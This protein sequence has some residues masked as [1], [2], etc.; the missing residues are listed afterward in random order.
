MVIVFSH[1]ANESPQVRREVE[2]AVAKGL[3][4]IPIRIEDVLP[5]KALEYFIS[6]AHW[7][8]AFPPPL[9]VHL[10]KLADTILGFLGREREPSPAVA[11]PV[12]P[13]SQWQSSTRTRYALIGAA[14]TLAILVIGGLYWLSNQGKVGPPA[15]VPPTTGPKPV[16]ASLGSDAAATTLDSKQA[17]KERPF[18]N[19]LGMEFV[20]MPGT[21]VLFCRWETRVKDWAAFARV[22]KLDGGWATQQK[23]SVHVKREPDHPICDVNWEDANAFCRWLTEKESAEGTLPKGMRYRLPTD[24]E[25]SRAVGLGKEEGA[26]PA[27]KSGKN[28]VDFPWGISWPP[29]G[30]AGN[31]ADEAYHAEFPVENWIKDYSDGFATTAPVGSFAPNEFGIYDLGGN[32][33]EWCEDLYE[34]GG[35]DRVLRGASWRDIDRNNLL[36]SNRHHYAPSLHYYS[37]YGFRCVVSA[38]A[39]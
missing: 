7:L 15:K 19:S 12:V 9:R 10:E 28:G 24:E 5:T 18:V 29:K 35:T 31:Y 8:D 25:W 36:S 21:Q 22:N 26:T 16:V 17:T 14:I 1:H 6:A 38:S 20:P 34:P 32:V 13:L 2:R 11:I 37:D 4:I 23:D 27:E 39:R 3:M 30:K 33:W